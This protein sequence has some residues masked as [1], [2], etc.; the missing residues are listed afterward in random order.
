MSG[1]WVAVICGVSLV[2]LLALTMVF[3]RIDSDPKRT[4]APTSVRA[5]TAPAFQQDDATIRFASAFGP[6]GRSG[7]WF[8]DGDDEVRIVVPL[9]D[10]AAVFGATP[11][12]ARFVGSNGSYV[13]VAVEK[14]DAARGP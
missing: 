11:F 7:L 10:P 6:F 8:F 4:E 2:L 14:G 13:D 9:S 1:R 5:A 3:P 12:V